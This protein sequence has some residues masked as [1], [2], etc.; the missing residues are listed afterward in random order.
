MQVTKATSHMYQLSHKGLG[1]KSDLQAM[2]SLVRDHELHLVQDLLTP[3]EH[4]VSMITHHI[5]GQGPLHSE[6]YLWLTVPLSAWPI[7]R[8]TVHP[9]CPCYSRQHTNRM[10][11]TDLHP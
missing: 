3:S 6:Q 5:G 7:P 2:L 10:I 9:M 4:L 1:T 11:N 8:V